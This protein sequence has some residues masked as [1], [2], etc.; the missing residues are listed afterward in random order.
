MS[1][2]ALTVYYYSKQHLYII[3]Q[4]NPSL[5]PLTPHPP[6]SQ[7]LL[8]LNQATITWAYIIVK[9]DPNRTW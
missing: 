4:D 9:F 8:Y 3:R 6:I 5:A 7:M 1:Y 2:L